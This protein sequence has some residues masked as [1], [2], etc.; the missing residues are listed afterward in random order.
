[1]SAAQQ[2]GARGSDRSARGA[3]DAGQARLPGT[4]E[5]RRAKG[6][7]APQDGAPARR[8]RADRAHRILRDQRA[9]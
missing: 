2:E 9:R 7:S 6:T 4:A 5:G 3:G 1:M 8:D